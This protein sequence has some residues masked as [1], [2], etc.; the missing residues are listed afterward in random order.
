M[1]ISSV[2]YK[3]EFLCIFS[4]E[5]IN[6]YKINFFRVRFFISFFYD[7]NYTFRLSSYYDFKNLVYSN[8]SKLINASM[9]ALNMNDIELNNFY[10]EFKNS[11]YYSDT[12]ELDYIK[13]KFYN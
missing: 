8:N 2:K 12:L 3:W 11:N 1:R 9:Q 10:K 7:Y 5:K 6:I 13:D 4:I